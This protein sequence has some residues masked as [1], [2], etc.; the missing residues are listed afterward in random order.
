ML[1]LL[2]GSTGPDVQRKAENGQKNG[3]AQRKGGQ[4]RKREDVELGLA[5]AGTELGGRDTFES[6]STSSCSHPSRSNGGAATVDG[7]GAEE[8]MAKKVDDWSV[9]EES[10]ERPSRQEEEEEQEEAEGPGSD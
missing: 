10:I 9:E 3:R 1:L 5:A 4:G 8:V 7:E 6:S 2:Y